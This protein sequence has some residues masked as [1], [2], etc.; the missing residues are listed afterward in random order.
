MVRTYALSSVLA[1]AGLAFGASAPAG[2]SPSG[3]AG[4]ASV[5]SGVAE[6][7]ITN[8]G[9]RG[10]RYWS[11]RRYYWRPRYYRPRVYYY[12]PRYYRRCWINGWGYRVCR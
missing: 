6:N 7:G 12:A 10:R 11:V 9:W 3:A 8:I 4:L 2:A 1:A 5:K